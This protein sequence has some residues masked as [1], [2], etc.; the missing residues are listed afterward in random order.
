M[1]ILAF[2]IIGVMFGAYVL[3]DGYDLGVAIVT[4]MVA[5]NDGERAQAM[6]N[7]GPFW[8]AN[9]V[10][11]V[12]AG[13]ALF[14]LFPQAYASSLSGFYLPFMVV[15]WLLMYRG[16]AVSVRDH[17]AN[18]LW[19]DF[20]DAGFVVSSTL[21]TILFGVALGN[22]V[23]GLPVDSH[24]YFV[25][26][27]SLL[28]NPYALGIGAFSLVALALHGATFSALRLSGPSAKRAQHAAVLLWWMVL[29]AYIGMSVATWFVR[30]SPF[31]HGMWVAILPVL[32]IAVLVVLWLANAAGEATKAFIASC[33]FLATLVA[34]AAIAMFPY[35]VP[36]LPGSHGLS[37]Y[38]STPSAIGLLSALAVTI[39]GIAL[40]TFYT[41]IVFRR[42]FAAPVEASEPLSAPRSR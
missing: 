6:H 3:S 16:I 40:I 26:S 30:L 37:I 19:H 2:V 15:L 42:L 38:D 29:V 13:G 39:A 33:A 18:P 22:L 14:A 25:G 23:R 34:E 7:I 27:F 8:H 9:Q 20:W 21:L 1:S 32:S 36:A 28:L 4:P 10:W 35:I 24:G 17:F 31:E 11:L 5:R 41:I 12:A